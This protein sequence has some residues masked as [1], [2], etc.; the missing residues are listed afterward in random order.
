MRASQLAAALAV[1]LAFLALLYAAAALSLVALQGVNP[2][3]W[4]ALR[5]MTGFVLLFVTAVMAML[6]VLAVV[7]APVPR[8][9]REA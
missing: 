8:E 4:E 3:S 9:R 1:V 6:T 5:I 7:L 2:L